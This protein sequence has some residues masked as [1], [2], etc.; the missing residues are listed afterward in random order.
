MLLNKKTI[1][2]ISLIAVLAIA[3]GAGYYFS[4]LKSPTKAPEEK[5]YAKLVTPK[6]QE[7]IK[8]APKVFQ[9]GR[10][11]ALPILMYHHVGQLPNNPDSTRV[12][13][14]VPTDNFEAQVKWLKDNKLEHKIF[15]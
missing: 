11:I 15:Q 2:N 3:A 14:T 1:I 6:D 8:I 10:A 13:L 9:N 5:T 12:D 7:P 4:R